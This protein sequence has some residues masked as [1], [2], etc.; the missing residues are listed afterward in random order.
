MKYQ[1]TVKNTTVMEFMT[2][3]VTLPEIFEKFEDLDIIS[4]FNSG[5]NLIEITILVDSDTIDIESFEEQLNEATLSP[6]S[7]II[8][9]QK[10]D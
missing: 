7:D 6:D 10:L 5:N 2:R 8:Y 3:V 4:V 1:L 9:W